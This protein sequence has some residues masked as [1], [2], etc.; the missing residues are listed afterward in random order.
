MLP[1]K[2]VNPTTRTAW[3][4]IG[5]IVLN[6]VIFLL[7]EP[8]FQSQAKQE[9]F[10]FCRAEIPYEVSHTTSLAQG[11][12]GAR[13]AIAQDYGPKAAAPLQRYLQQQC[14]NK[15]WLL[16]ILVAMFLHGGWL[17]IAGNMLYLWIFGNNVE[18]RLGAL[19][20]LAFYLLGGIAASALELAFGPNSTVPTLGASGAIAAVLGG[21]IVLFPKARVKTLVFFFFITWIELPASVVLGVW[22]VLQLFSG[23]GSVGGQMSDVA[24]WAHVGGFV[25]GLAVAWLFYRGRGARG[26]PEAAGYRY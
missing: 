22:F 20:Y 7:W 15:N 24:Y 25:F 9:T 1:L 5:L 4:T 17:H 8:T 12:A 23:V 2:D 19:P 18:D 26:L 13:H 10:F 6:V 14:P 16:S 3:V 21:Y 11:G